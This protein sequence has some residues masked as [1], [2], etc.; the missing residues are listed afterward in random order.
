MTYW[1]KQK[2]EHYL[3]RGAVIAKAIEGFIELSVSIIL[4]FASSEF[5]VRI[6]YMFFGGEFAEDPADFVASH[7]IHISQGLTHSMQLFIA[8]YFLVHGIINLGIALSLWYKN[9]W[10]YPV[11]AV[12]LSILTLY[13]IYR[14]IY[15]FSFALLFIIIVNIVIIALL[16][17]EYRRIRRNKS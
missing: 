7:I 10:A 13:Q 17:F 11:A 6:I 8:I 9:T 14:L 16:N 1:N 12:I 15:T 4:F 3:F 5:I 2:V